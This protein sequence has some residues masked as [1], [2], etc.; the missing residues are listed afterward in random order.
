MSAKAEGIEKVNKGLIYALA[1]ALLDD[2]SDFADKHSDDK[3]NEAE[4]ILAFH[5]ALKR[6]LACRKEGVS[7]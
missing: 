3:V 1:T 2:F 6:V 7:A 5:V 4:I